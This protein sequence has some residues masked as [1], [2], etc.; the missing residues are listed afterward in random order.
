MKSTLLWAVAL[1]LSHAAQ[2]DHAC[3][4]E[5]ASAC[6]ERPGSEVAACLK[7]ESQHES[8]TELSSE[9]TDFMA[10]NKACAAEIEQFCEG[11]FFHDDTLLCLSKWTKPEDL[12]SQCS[13]VMAWSV[14]EEEEKKVVTDELG[15]SDADYQEKKEWMKKRA[16]AR[17]DSIE[18]L[19]QKEVDRKKEEERRAMEDFKNTDPEGYKQEMERKEEDKKQQEAFKRKERARLAAIERAKKV[20]EG[21]SED[22]EPMKDAKGGKKSK[23]TKKQ[24]K[25]SWTSKL[26][27]VGILCFIGALVW[28]FYP[29]GSGGG[30]GKKRR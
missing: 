10:M 11:Q 26:V 17:G 30:K 5:V 4:K 16:A 21:G 2:A 14:P 9:C 24:S 6:P 22:E 29:K 8:P 28:Y 13:T 15:M 1:L 3:S 7:D 18:R 12:G 23:N 20:S 19:K 25:E 27:S